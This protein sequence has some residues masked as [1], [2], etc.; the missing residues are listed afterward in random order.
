M[1]SSKIIRRAKSMVYFDD[2]HC[3]YYINLASNVWSV[4]DYPG[5]VSR[6][7][8]FYLY[9]HFVFFIDEEPTEVIKDMFMA[10]GYLT[11]VSTLNR[12]VVEGCY[13]VIFPDVQIFA[14][15]PFPD[16]NCGHLVCA[17]KFMLSVETPRKVIGVEG[18][19]CLPKQTDYHLRMLNYDTS[20]M[21][22]HFLIGS[23]Y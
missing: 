16:Y 22:S 6:M 14:L 13:S 15:Y 2:D 9:K 5:C 8:L 19:L 11:E 10:T 21:S 18:V 1:E 3:M 17:G 20:F 4:E 12:R 7:G 23:A